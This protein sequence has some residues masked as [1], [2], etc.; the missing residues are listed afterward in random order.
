MPKKTFKIGEYCKGGVITVE[1]IGKVVTVIGKDW[2]TSAGYKKSSNQSNA[3]EFTRGSVV[4][5][6]ASAERLLDKF[7]NDLTT[8]YWS[9]KI[10]CWIKSNV[11]FEQKEWW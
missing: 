1:I 4:T 11:K 9:D 7:L 2:D 5:C 3:K 6:D 10:L 8:S